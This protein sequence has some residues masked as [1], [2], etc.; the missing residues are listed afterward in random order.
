MVFYE[1]QSLIHALMST[2]VQLRRAWMSNY[3]SLYVCVFYLYLKYFTLCG[4]GTLYGNRY[5]SI[6]SP[7][8]GFYLISPSHCL[9]QCWLSI[10]EVQ[11]QFHKRF[12]GHQLQICL[13]I[14]FLKFL[15]Y[16]TGQMSW[17]WLR[18]RKSLLVKKA[19]SFI[20]YIFNSLWNWCSKLRCIR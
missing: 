5:G 7:G 4:L 15:P 10:N 1:I 9:C 3:S 14:T 16:L 11:W 8:N 18:F 20:R 6:I 19:L 12:P 17:T 13:K 2:W